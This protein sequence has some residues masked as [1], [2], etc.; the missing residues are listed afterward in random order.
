[1][2]IFSAPAATLSRLV[3]RDDTTAAD[4][5]QYGYVPQEY[6]AIMF[7]A[8]YGI[9]TSYDFSVLSSSLTLKINL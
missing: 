5:E 1:M 6:V 4:D 7:L 8:L 3:I 9:S 2:F